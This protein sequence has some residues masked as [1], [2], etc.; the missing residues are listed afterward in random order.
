M[1]KREKI[2]RITISIEE[3]L[4]KDLLE[5]TKQKKKSRAVNIACREFVRIKQLNDLVRLKEKFLSGSFR[6]VK[7]D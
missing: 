5:I 3:S 4:L 7:D 1:K 2:N 6:G